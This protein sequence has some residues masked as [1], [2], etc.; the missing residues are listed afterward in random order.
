[1]IT[2]KKGDLLAVTTGVII[3]GCNAQGVM[4][5]GVAKQIRD[6]YPQAYKAYLEGHYTLGTVS[7]AM[8]YPKLII[9]NAI[10]QKYY[11]NQINVVYVD[12]GAVDKCFKELTNVFAEDIPFHIPRIGAGLAQGDWNVIEDIINKNT[13]GYNVTC[14]DL[15]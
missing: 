12:Y 3:H 9:A 11:G 14:W 10:T 8:I 4:G 13:Q 7:L 6:K 15:M 2:Y 5:A 1:M